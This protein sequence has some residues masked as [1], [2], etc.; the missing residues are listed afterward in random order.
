MKK[1]ILFIICVF[2]I[3]SCT[4]FLSSRTNLPHGWRLPSKQEAQQNWRS[5]DINRYLFVKAD[6][7]GDNILDEAKLLISDISPGFAL[8]AFLSQSDGTFKTYLLDEKNDN[9]YVKSLGIAKVPAG[10]YK[11]VC[12]KGVIECGDG[13]VEEVLLHYDAINYFK[14]ES[15]NMYFYWDIMSNTFKQAWIND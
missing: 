12:G 8:F 1:A 9:K 10:L 15:A 7:N 4:A 11:T 6:F 5:K 3:A 13:Q 14:I 2:G